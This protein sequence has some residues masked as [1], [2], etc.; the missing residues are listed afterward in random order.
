MRGEGKPWEE[1]DVVNFSV[2][3]FYISHRFVCLRNMIALRV[4]VGAVHV[5]ACFSFH[6][7]P[8]CIVFFCD[9]ATL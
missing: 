3:K 9:H 6:L 5:I 8:D 7:P 1:E 2:G 4:E